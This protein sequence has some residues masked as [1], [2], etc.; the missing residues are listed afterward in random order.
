MFLI[1][2]LLFKLGRSGLDQGFID[3]GS[4]SLGWSFCGGGGGGRGSFPPCFQNYTD[5]NTSTAYSHYNHAVKKI[6]FLACDDFTSTP[7]NL[8]LW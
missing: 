3:C 4:I 1:L 5:L 6:K 8:H 2:H 7:E